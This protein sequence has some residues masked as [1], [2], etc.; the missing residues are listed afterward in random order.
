MLGF[1]KKNGLL[2]AI[3][4][5][6]LCG[7]SNTLKLSVSKVLDNRDKF[8]NKNIIVNGIILKKKSSWFI[9]N[10]NNESCVSLSAQKDV[11]DEVIKHSGNHISLKGVFLD[12]E[13]RSNGDTDVFL[14]SRFFVSKIT[15]T[16]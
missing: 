3:L 1:I 13:F 11:F 8:I 14:P 5:A 15:D 16:P 7:C 2:T 6:I 4:L 10:E 12:H 9:C